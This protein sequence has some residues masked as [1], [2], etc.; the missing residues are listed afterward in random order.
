M[1]TCTS[2]NSADTI[3]KHKTASE[4]MRI[5]PVESKT[6]AMVMNINDKHDSVKSINYKFIE[7]NN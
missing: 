7:N 6:P 5:I 1:L 4:A 2:G 3:N